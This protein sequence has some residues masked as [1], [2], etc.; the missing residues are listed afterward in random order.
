[1]S[2][3]LYRVIMALAL[4]ALMSSAAALAE[5]KTKNVTFNDDVKIGSTLVKKGTYKVTF[6]DQTNE[7]IVAKNNK[8]IAK[9]QARLEKIA[10]KASDSLYSTR[11]EG[12]KILTSVTMESG[13]RAIIQHEDN[14]STTAQ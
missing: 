11:M 8:T 7:L 3:I 5:K 6:D 4:C 14:R 10:G 9:T 2:K 1:M 12:E 13:N